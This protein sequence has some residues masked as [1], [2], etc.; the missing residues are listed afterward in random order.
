MKKTFPVHLGSKT[1]QKLSGAILR[2]TRKVM[3]SNRHLGLQLAELP[4]G[5][6]AKLPEIGR[7]D[8]PTVADFDTWP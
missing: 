6:R 5:C 7:E 1:C 3:F 2:L 4:T 8:K